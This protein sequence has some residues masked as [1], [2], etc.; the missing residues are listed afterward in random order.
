MSNQSKPLCPECQSADPVVKLSQVYIAGITDQKS[1]SEE[2]VRLL[3][4]I[5][6]KAPAPAALRKDL[7]PFSP[8][9]GGSK[10]TRPSNPD[11]VMVALSA[12]MVVFL[13]NIYVSQ[14][15][16][17]PVVLALAAA[18]VIGFVFMRPRLWL[19]YQ[20]EQEN[21]RITQ[22][23]VKE[24]VERWMQV[25]YCADDDCVFDPKREGSVPLDQVNFFLS[26]DK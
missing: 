18:I 7:L 21:L 3:E 26:T 15:G 2:D 6:G 5:F 23:S 9:S 14:T 25:Y 13:Y 17:F 16:L 8:P 11:I 22:D 20:A 19:R 24:Y 4:R 1:R 12:I 10:L